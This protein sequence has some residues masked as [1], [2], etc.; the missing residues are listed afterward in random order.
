MTPRIRIGFFAATALVGFALVAGP[1][2]ADMTD[3]PTPPPAPSSD[4]TK[5]DEKKTNAP[6]QDNKKKK[7]EQTGQQFLDNYKVAYRLIKSG[8]YRP[9]IEAMRALGQDDHPD[10]A[11][12]IGYAYRKL[13]QYDQAKYWY[14]KALAADP[15]HV[16][17]LSYYGMLYVEQGD[18]A[19]ARKLLQRIATLCGNTSCDPYEDLEQVIAGKAHY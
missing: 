10:V 5:K 13:H 4:N 2:L 18:K 11:T 16:L 8:K 14:D 3:K 19:T 12:S 1:A 9:G 15:N 17:T 6:K 7:P